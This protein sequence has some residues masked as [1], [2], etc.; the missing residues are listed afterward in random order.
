MKGEDF[1]KRKNVMRLLAI[2]IAASV[3]VTSPALP[4]SLTTVQAGD[5][6]AAAP[7]GIT[8]DSA[9]RKFVITITDGASAGDYDYSLDGGSTWTNA[10]AGTASGTTLTIT[11]DSSD[12]KAYAVGTIK[13]R[14][15]SDNTSDNWASSAEALTAALDGT[16]SLKVTRSGGDVQDGTIKPGDIITASVDT[17]QTDATLQ[18]KF[19][20]NTE[21][22]ASATTTYEVT[23]D[24]LGKTISVEVTASNS[25]LYT[26]KLTQNASVA[27]TSAA[28][29][30]ATTP[31]GTVDFDFGANDT[32]DAYTIAI[33]YSGSNDY[34]ATDLVYSTDGTTF[35]SKG[36]IE[37]DTF[38]PGTQ[39]TVTA[40]VAETTEKL[41]SDTKSSEQKTAPA[42]LTKPTITITAG[43]VEIS[44][45]QGCTIH[46]TID[47]TAPTTTTGTEYTGAFT[48]DDG[49]TVK[50]IAYKADTIPSEIASK[51]YTATEGGDKEAEAPAA[52]TI[53]ITSGSVTISA[54]EGCKIYYTT[55]GTTPTTKSTEYTGAFTVADGVTVTAIASRETDSKVSATASKK[56]TAPANDNK[57][58][59]DS[60]TTTPSTDKDK[61][62]TDKNTDDT[63][64]SSTSTEKT[65]ETNAAGK[66]VTTTTT[67]KTDAEGN[68]T[69]VT[70]KSV[71]AAVAK[72]TSASVTVKKDGEGEVTSATAAVTKTVGDTNKV[73]IS[74]AVVDQLTEAAGTDDVKVTV[75]VKDADGKTK[76][77][78]KADADELTAGKDLYIYKLD[79]KTGEYVMVNAKTYTVSASGSVSV[80][81][82]EKA[83]YELV[84]AKEAKAIEKKILKTVQVKKSTASVKKGKTTTVALASGVNKNNIKKI[85]Y[86]T[87]KK[88]VATVSKTGKITT[89]SKGTVTVKAKVTLK[90]GTTKTVKMTVKVK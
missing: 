10:A 27:V 34:T 46:Y 76:Y 2:A 47:G 26:G 82:T 30:K 33:T 75:T 40:K 3:A 60:N 32:G 4:V 57:D 89:K 78:V 52:P 24:D 13:A 7:T 84:T 15:A 39:V 16:V 54:G 65:T 18:Y 6:D 11:L 55:D 19:T 35:K 20:G 70:E 53:T 45:D 59:N 21:G 69:S 88:S 36:D 58:G 81:M 56:Y 73:S 9:N 25:N 83:T 48:V 12:K 85:T 37:K 74:G 8:V 22:A 79:T 49:V 41:E 42:A 80:S 43:S 77:K 86:T 90:N 71:I 61:T 62:D 44:A 67:T 38:A 72:N 68:V 17:T 31:A 63:T 14:L 1:M 23:A 51:T 87:S 5:V 66:E 50:A 29:E 28:T 64:A